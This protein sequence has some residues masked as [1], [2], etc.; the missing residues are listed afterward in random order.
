VLTAKK[1]I[2]VREAIPHSTTGDFFYNARDWFQENTKLVGGI[3]LGV[4][5]VAIIGYLYVTGQQA[6]D[7]QANLE[8]NKVQPLYQNQQY[9]LAITGDPAQQ[10]PGLT[11]ISEKYSNTATGQVA[12]LYLGNCYLYTG[13]FDKAIEA[14]K[15]SSPDDA[16]LDAAVTAGMAAAYEAK[17]EYAE[18]ADL[19]KSAAKKFDNDLVSSE[20]YFYAG[21][22]YALSGDMES[23]KEMLE[24]SKESKNQRFHQQA[25]RLLA[26]YHLD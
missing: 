3:V 21:R 1:K 26:E 7:L 18:A 4:I 15:E 5:A 12:S 19:F 23:A 20:R 24:K 25:D 10:I 22:A 2:N 16:L 17:K 13:E 14:F 9:K 6:D 11:E 8:L